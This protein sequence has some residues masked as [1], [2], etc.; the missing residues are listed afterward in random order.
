MILWLYSAIRVWLHISHVPFIFQRLFFFLFDSHFPPSY[1]SLPIYIASFTE[2]NSS[3]QYPK[4]WWWL[5]VFLLPEFRTEYIFG[6]MLPDHISLRKKQDAVGNSQTNSVSCLFGLGSF[7]PETLCGY[8]F[9]FENVVP[10][11]IQS[12]NEKLYY[13]ELNTVKYS[14]IQ[15]PSTHHGSASEAHSEPKLSLMMFVVQWC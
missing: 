9:W 8:L 14:I 4:G 6:Q 2:L 10:C 3:L 15:L 7:T 5:Y 11:L 13:L 1:S 12:G